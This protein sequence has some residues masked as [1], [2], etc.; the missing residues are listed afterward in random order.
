MNGEDFTNDKGILAFMGN[1]IAPDSDDEIVA[2][3][4]RRYTSCES[5]RRGGH[6]VVCYDNALSKEVWGTHEFV[7]PSSKKKIFVPNKL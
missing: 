4:Q 6:Q 2:V 1:G 3:N 7:S 5:G